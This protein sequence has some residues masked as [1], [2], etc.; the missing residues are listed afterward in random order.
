M[1]TIQTTPYFQRLDTV[2][3]E[4][5]SLLAD[6][7][8]VNTIFL[9]TNDGTSNF[10][11]KAFNRK[12]EL[13]LEGESAPF[14]NVLC[15]LAVENEGEP[16]V[17][18]DLAKNPKTVQH[19]ITLQVGSGSFLGAPIY[20]GNGEVFGTLCAFDTEPY[21]FSQKDVRL[22][23][24]FSS[25]LSQTIFL[26]EMMVHDHLTGLYNSFFLKAF[27]EEQ[28]ASCPNY[29]VLYID[30]DNFKE[31]NDTYGHD[32]GD[33]LLT[34]VARIFQKVAPKDSITARIGG[35]EF[36]LL[37][38]LV[39]NDLTQAEKAATTLL[40]KLTVEPVIVEG[41][42]FLISASIGVT[43]LDASKELRHLIKEADEAMYAAKR[44]GRGRIESHQ[45]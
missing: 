16:I 13:L 8:G 42:P 17:I 3:E 32:M 33:R 40:Q 23:K 18:P 7:I 21:N 11:V 31:V 5:I 28:K 14:E 30:L 22:V 2:A 4:V 36:V 24:T 26:E 38:P 15:K 19:P 41:I 43:L 10:I 35:D 39:E 27:F 34:Q 37:I 9:A 45:S 1:A 25:L 20:K 12:A 29:A 44:S 6:T